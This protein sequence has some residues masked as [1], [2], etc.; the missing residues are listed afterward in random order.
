MRPVDADH[1]MNTLLHNW[2]GHDKNIVPYSDRK[3]YRLRDAEV[4]T[5]IINEPL[6]NA[7]TAE[8]AIETV[9]ETILGFVSGE[10][11][12]NKQD[13]LLLSVNKA[14]CDNL[15]ELGKGGNK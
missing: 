13:L 8:Q 11:T 14:I 9:H 10:G 12:F 15:R 2:H 1:L 6:L 5:A 4:R 3:G 7:L